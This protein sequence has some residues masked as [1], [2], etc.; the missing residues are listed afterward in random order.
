M[1]LLNNLLFQKIDN[2]DKIPYRHRIQG[3]ID[4]REEVDDE[5]LERF[6][7]QVVDDIHHDPD[8]FT[9]AGE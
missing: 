4:L 1:S 6:W 5:S 3:R 8:W 7:D 9:F 2:S